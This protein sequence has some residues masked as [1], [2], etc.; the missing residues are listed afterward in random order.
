MVKET[1]GRRDQHI[2]A[3]LELAE[4][5]IHRDAA[6]EQR[7]REL[8][9][10][11]IGLEAL[12]DL[13]GELAGRGEDQRA[14]HPRAG[15]AR[16]EARE[17]RQH[18]RRRLSGAGLCDSEDVTARDGNGDGLGLDRCRRRV[19]DGVDCG[20]DLGAEPELSERRE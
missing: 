15:P 7:H 18:V 1:T 2:G 13:G 9:I 10:D 20:E 17:H 6:D 3:T 16:L 19:S 8:V 11:A 14:R 12:G 5:V 4:L